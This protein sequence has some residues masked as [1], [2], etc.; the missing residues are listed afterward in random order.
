MFLTVLFCF[1]F[2]SEFYFLDG[3]A[4]HLQNGVIVKTVAEVSENRLFYNWQEGE[5]YISIEKRNVKTVELFSLKV[6]GRKPRTVFKNTTRRRIS[7][8]P[9]AYENKKGETL[10][11]TRHVNQRGRSMEG[12][13]VPNRVERLVMDQ[14]A[15]GSVFTVEFDKTTANTNVELRFYNLK[16]DLEAKAFLEVADPKTNDK[17]IRNGKTYSWNFGLSDRI[18]VKKIGLVE[19]LTVEE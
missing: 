4:F 2:Q 11:K 16:G 10:L 3:H 6:P 1:A 15:Q 9:V 8:I 19:V 14:A 13:P 7:G 12:K 18:Q 5:S 17:L